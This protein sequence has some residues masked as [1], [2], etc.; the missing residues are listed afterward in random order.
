M[1]TT[2][3]TKDTERIAAK[4]AKNSKRESLMFLRSFAAF[5]FG[6]GSAALR[7]SVVPF[8]SFRLRMPATEV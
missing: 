5:I 2:E 4:N 1:E 6:C 3:Y 7:L 8:E